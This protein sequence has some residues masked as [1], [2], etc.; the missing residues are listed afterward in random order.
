M[1]NHT[2]ETCHAITQILYL[3]RSQTKAME[4]FIERCRQNANVWASCQNESNNIL[5]PGML[6]SVSILNECSDSFTSAD[7]KHQKASTWFFCWYRTYGYALPPWQSAVDSQH[8]I[9][10]QKAALHICP[11]TEA[12]QTSTL[13]YHCQNSLQHWLSNPLELHQMGISSR[14]SA[15]HVLRHFCL[16]RI[17]PSVALPNCLSPTKTHRIWI[18]RWRG[19]WE[20]LEHFEEVNPWF[21]HLQGE[22]W[23]LIYY[24][25]FC[26]EFMSTSIIKEYLRWMPKSNILM[27]SH[28]CYLVIGFTG[29]GSTASARSM[30]PLLYWIPVKSLKQFFGRSG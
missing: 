4:E 23:K 3:W 22:W 14:I 16:S 15:T 8:D 21:T 7:E 19:V 29:A 13:R 2:I 25:L 11:A 6:V 26:V 24:P 18:N 1:A 27:N 12:I 5:E 17:Q 9:S 20:I 30:P 10:R 28:F